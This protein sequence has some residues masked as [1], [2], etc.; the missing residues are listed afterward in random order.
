MNKKKFINLFAILVALSQLNVLEARTKRLSKLQETKQAN[1]ETVTQAY[2]D[3][4]LM[5]LTTA[6]EVIRT[7][8]Y[9]HVWT[10]Y[11]EP[12]LTNVFHA[13]KLGHPDALT[14]KEE[15]LCFINENRTEI[16]NEILNKKQRSNSL[17]I[18]YNSERYIPTEH[19]E[20]NFLK[21]KACFKLYSHLNKKAIRKEIVEKDLRKART[22]L[23][24]SI[25]FFIT[26]A[27]LGY[28]KSLQEA[29]QSLELLEKII[30]LQKELLNF[31][32]NYT[33]KEINEA[34]KIIEE[35]SQVIQQDKENSSPY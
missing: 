29:K 5:N 34:R 12:S 17:K 19:F 4:A 27:N 6:R 14:L 10:V 20:G 16:D 22:A 13:Q 11:L 30:L 1:Q 23:L 15:I 8:S 26:S 32:L 28:Q 21:Q 9:H 31:D 2:Y 3:T 25:S 33:D 7:N 18:N 24:A 35:K